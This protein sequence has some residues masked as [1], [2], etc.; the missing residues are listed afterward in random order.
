MILLQNAIGNFS[1]IELT[2]SGVAVLGLFVGWQNYHEAQKDIGALGGIRNG[3]W[4]IARGNI[5]RERVRAI[6]FVLFGGLGVI[7]GFAPPNPNATP[8]SLVL[9]SGLVVTSMLLAL[10]SF[11]DRRDRVYLLHYTPTVETQD[12][13]EDREFGDKR[14]ELEV[15][16]NKP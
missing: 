10:N 9:S 4:R 6:I 2:W 13:R 16:H 11:Y 12:Q 15:E 1:W 3:R 5:R 8:T 7:A 14:R